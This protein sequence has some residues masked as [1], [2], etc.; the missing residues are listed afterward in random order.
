V[1]AAVSAQQHAQRRL[2]EA[3]EAHISPLEKAWEA[4]V[5]RLRTLVNACAD[6]A[7]L[8]IPEDV[9]P[10][11]EQDEKTHAVTGFVS[12]EPKP[13][14]PEEKPAEKAKPEAK[15][16]EPEKVTCV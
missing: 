9:R 4:E 16:P 1:E 12:W 10:T 11:I 14:E 8:S 13:E 5:I 2:N 7:G 6:E 15:V 3:Y